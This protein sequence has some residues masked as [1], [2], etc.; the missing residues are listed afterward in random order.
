MNAEVNFPIYTLFRS[1]PQQVLTN[2]NYTYVP[3]W[4][5]LTLRHCSFTDGAE[6]S[7]R[8]AGRDKTPEKTDPEGAR[9]HRGHRALPG[10]VGASAPGTELCLV[11]A[12]HTMEGS[13]S[14]GLTSH[15]FSSAAG[16]SLHSRGRLSNLKSGLTLLP[17][18][19]APGAEQQGVHRVSGE[20]GLHPTGQGCEARTW[21]SRERRGENR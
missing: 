6:G 4:A 19:S 13:A 3:Y 16:L 12:T 2:L 15:P 1:T 21:R 10:A 9:R 14:L 8:A 5:L 20:R 7:V 17:A 11:T 18:A